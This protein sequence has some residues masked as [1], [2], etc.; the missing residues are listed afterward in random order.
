MPLSV[1]CKLV[2]NKREYLGAYT[3]GIILSLQLKKHR[4]LEM[5]GGRGCIDPGNLNFVIRWR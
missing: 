4:D 2:T 5:Y 1:S 3:E